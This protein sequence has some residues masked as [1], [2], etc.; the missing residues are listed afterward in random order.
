M[1]VQPTTRTVGLSTA[2]TTA[3]SQATERVHTDPVIALEP[4]SV[5]IPIAMKL[6]G[7]GR[8]KLYELIASG[9]LEIIKIGSATL[10]TMNSLRRL[11]VPATRR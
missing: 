6:T 1:P 3:H 10:V 9:D 5:R 7:I 4:L 11:V 8:T 2:P